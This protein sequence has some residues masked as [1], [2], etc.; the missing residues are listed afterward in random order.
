MYQLQIMNPEQM[1]FDDEII[2]LIAP[3][4]N[5]Y[6]GVLT[7]HTPL[8]VS[9]REGILIITDK[10]NKKTYYE[11]S[12]GFLEVNGNKASILIETIHPTAPVDIGIQGEI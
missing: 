2:A 7:G 8:L 12:P 5:G 1:I 6:L 3:G 4:E 11:I 9:L 10:Y